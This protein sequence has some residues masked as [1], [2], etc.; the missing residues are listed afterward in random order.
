MSGEEVKQPEVAQGASTEAM[1]QEEAPAAA[2][3]KR[4]AEENP[5]P[6]SELPTAKAA[7]TEGGGVAEGAVEAGEAAEGAGG[8]ADCG[9]AA[10]EGEPAPEQSAPVQI[11]YK[12]FNNGKDAKGY[13]HGLITKLRKYQNLNDVSAAR[14]RKLSAHVVAASQCSCCRRCCCAPCA[15]SVLLSLRAVEGQ[16]FAGAEFL[17]LPI[18]VRTVAQ[19]RQAPTSL[20]SQHIARASRSSPV[21]T[22]TTTHNTSPGAVRVPHGA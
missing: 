14:R 19:R 7:K 4:K 2:G 10:A 9:D 22:A 16:E 13:Y 20:L 15:F 12:T 6:E 8:E 21:P 1:E 5:A 18:W 17:S 3:T 11:G